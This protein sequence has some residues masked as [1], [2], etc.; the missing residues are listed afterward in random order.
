MTVD[1]YKRRRETLRQEF[2]TYRDH[3]WDIAQHFRP[4]RGFHLKG[5]KVDG[6]KRHMAIVNGTPLRVSKNAQSGLQAGITS[7]SRPWKKL[8]P[9]S[10]KAN[11]IP[12][13]KEFYA[14]VD[15]QMDF[16]LGKSNFY[17]ATHTAY[18][19][20]VDFGPGA[21]QIDEDDEDVIR[22]QVHPI[23]SWVGA[24]N[25]RGRVD[26]FYRDYT[27]RGS[28][29]VEQF[30]EE[31]IPKPLMQKIRLNP[32]KKIDLFNAIEP[33]PYYVKGQDA[34]GLASFPYVSVF[35]VR[36]HD[37]KFLDIRGYHEFPV[38]VFR[39]AKSED[40]DAYGYGPGT[41]GL[42]DAKGLQSLE[43]KEYVGLDKMVAP[44]LQAPLSMKQ[45][46]VSQ[47]PNKVNYVDGEQRITSLYDL[48]LPL[49]YVQSKEAQCE[50]R[51]SEAFFEDLFLMIT[52]DVQRQTTAREIDERHEEKLV[53]L[54]PVLESLNDELLDPAIDRIIGVMRR[55]NRMPQAPPDLL[56]EEFK[57][58]YISILAQAQ[59][60]IQTI[61]IEQGINF[62]T[63][64]AGAGFPDILDRIDIDDTVEAYFDR[65]GYPPEGIRA[66][67][68]AQAMREQRAADAAQERNL[69][70]AAEGASAASDAVGAAGAAQQIQPNVLQ[71]LLA[72]QQ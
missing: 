25:A 7:P 17:R 70:M 14:E 61:P 26:V 5:M 23:G 24:C 39:F 9:R 69:A 35:W 46:G 18:A 36:G 63:A 13:A 1:T 38:M 45:K 51:L 28:E 59:R 47:V 4:R 21:I 8:G 72:G 16:I 2:S 57:T 67:K 42:G 65:I 20:F 53:M 49:Q 37:E 29:L 33:N 41:D 68:D 40:V 48:N 11:D 66:L 15:R 55:A 52:R 50:R 34:I 54:G 60:A 62:A 32:M 56:G 58:E 30:G 19:D 6:K 3:F 64:A 71:Q 27:P 10:T 22:C 43:R 12:G 31:K 44:P